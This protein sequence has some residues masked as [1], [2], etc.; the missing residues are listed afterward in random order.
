MTDPT[1]IADD[2]NP[3][4]VVP[5]VKGQRRFNVMAKP[6][7][8]ACNLACTYCYYLSKERLLG[9]S[10]HQPMADDVLEKFI[11]DYIAD[12]DAPQVEF[13]WQGGEPTL[14]GVDFFRKVVE[15]QKKHCPP[16]KRVLNN[17][18]TNGLLLDDPWC[19]FLH[20]N[21]FLVGLSIDGPKKLHDAY[22]VTKGGQPTFDRVFAA[23]KLLKK[24]QVDF[25]TLT[26]LHRL[27]VQRP[28][29]VYRFLSREVGPRVMQF[30]PLVEPRGFETVAP[31][32]RDESTA[33]MVGTPCAKPGTPDSIV[34]EWSV[35]ADDFGTFLC[36]VFDDWQQRDLGRHFVNLF[37]SWAAVWMGRPA[38]ISRLPRLLRQS[39]AAGARRQPLQLRPFRL[40]GVPAGEHPREALGRDRFF[41]PP[42]AVRLG[43]AGRAARVLP[44]LRVPVCLLGRVP[45]QPLAAVA[46][47]RAGPE[48][49]LPRLATL[50][51]PCRSAAQGNCRAIPPRRI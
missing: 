17:L 11:G 8:P 23:A 36:K 25:N 32:H 41:R 12:N 18:Q 33:P 4:R 46:R 37:E 22:R 28:L 39:P 16:H 35:D 42:G 10:G 19:R 6:L 29:D 14:L 15:L 27:N 3:L 24:H 47:G 9:L 2:D 38:Q 1:R 51:R 40:S 43:Q 21:Q 5:I 50:L 7:G 48:L 34:T 30:I 31:G 49:S 13:E 45:A 26:V 44:G 20:E